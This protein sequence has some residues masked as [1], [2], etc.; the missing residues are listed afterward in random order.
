[1]YGGREAVSQPDV[2]GR[3]CVLHQ[4]N[5]EKTTAFLVDFF[6][7]LIKYPEKK[8]CKGV[9]VCFNLWYM[10]YSALWWGEEEQQEHKAADHIALAHKHKVTLQPQSGSQE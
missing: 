7:A 8:Q 2:S 5:I 3:L 6:S 1:M 9:R 10:G 4:W